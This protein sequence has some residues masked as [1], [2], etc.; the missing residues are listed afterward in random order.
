MYRI[1]I[2]VDTNSEPAKR[3]A[4]VVGGRERSGVA[5]GLI[6]SVSTEPLQSSGRPVG[7]TA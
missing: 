2:P 6:G 3:Q 4:V 1:S 5:K 7:I